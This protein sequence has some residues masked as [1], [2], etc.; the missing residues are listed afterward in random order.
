MGKKTYI[1]FSESH[2]KAMRQ[3][4]SRASDALSLA[5]AGHVKVT[6]GS[7]FARW[8]GTGPRA[9]V[10]RVLQRMNYSMINGNIEISYVADGICQGGFVNA[11]AFRPA[12]GWRAANITEAKAYNFNMSICPRFLKIM[13]AE[14]SSNQSQVGTLVH[15]ISHLLGGTQDIVDPNSGD[16]VYGAT[17]AKALA[18]QFPAL[19]VNNAENYGFYV[20]EFLAD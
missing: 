11:M 16:V 8:F 17:A 13:P 12:H 4:V 20:A 18:A 14:G 2:E 15:E 6:D 5:Y 1:D 19:A 10:Q 9:T 3:V 7:Q